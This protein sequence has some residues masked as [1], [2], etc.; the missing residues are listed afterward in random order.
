MIRCS[1]RAVEL[2]R[3]SSRRPSDSTPA[4][5]SGWFR[6]DGGVRFELTD[7]PSPATR[8]SGTRR[9]HLFVAAGLSGIVDVD[10][11]HDRL[12]LLPDP[13]GPGGSGR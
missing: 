1:P 3:R 13:G 11:P 5:A 9:I 2:L 10:D 8:S 7:A 6:S 12:V 4:R